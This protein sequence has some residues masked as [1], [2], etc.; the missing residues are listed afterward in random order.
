[1]LRIDEGVEGRS[2]GELFPLWTAHDPLG[3]FIVGW[4]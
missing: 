2:A 4:R 1:M 3:D